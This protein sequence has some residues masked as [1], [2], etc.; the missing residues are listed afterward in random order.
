VLYIRILLLSYHTY[1]V[2]QWY[3]PYGRI[4]TVYYG[5][6]NTVY[7]SRNSA[8]CINT[9][10]QQTYIGNVI[11]KQGGDLVKAER[12]VR[13]AYRIRAQLPGEPLCLG[14]TANILGQILSSKC[15]F[16]EAKKQYERFLAI[17]MRHEGPDGVN[18]AIANDNLG[19]P[20]SLILTP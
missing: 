3:Y 18:T 5:R 11:S 4:N 13:E 12:L 1:H 2:I 8:I 17:S 14:L 19:K 7:F 9:N 6:I 20:L 10:T 15:N 16:D